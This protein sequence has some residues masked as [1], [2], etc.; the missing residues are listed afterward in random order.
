MCHSRHSH[1]RAVARPADEP[2][3]REPTFRASDSDREEIVTEL[4][5]HGAAGRLDV[6]E[7]EQRIEAA[8]SARTHGD[9]QPL[10]ADLPR[11][12]VVPSRASDFHGLHNHDWRVFAAVNALLVAIWAV[13]GAGYFWPGWVMAWWVFAIVMKS[14]PGL[15][16]AST[17]HGRDSAR[18]MQ[19]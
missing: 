18:L 2:Q 7:L 16:R 8:Y 14:T 13:S 17:L 11:R 9:L 15:L 5:V 4:R 3:R 6:E 12:Q 1:R 19:R 10:L